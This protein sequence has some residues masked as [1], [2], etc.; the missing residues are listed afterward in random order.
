[1][2]IER[3]A[4]CCVEVGERLQRIFKGLTPVQK[5]LAFQTL[6]CYVLCVGVLNAPINR[7]VDEYALCVGLTRHSIRDRIDEHKAQTYAQTYNIN[8][9]YGEF[10]R[11]SRLRRECS[12]RSP[13]PSAYGKT[14]IYRGSSR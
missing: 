13:T 5:F 7:S 9:N 6:L 11:K 12:L 3:T 14:P 4:S 8:I 2:E 10:R 1:M